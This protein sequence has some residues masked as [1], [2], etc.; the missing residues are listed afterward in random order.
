[1]KKSIIIVALLLHIFVLKSQIYVGHRDQLNQPVLD[2]NPE[3]FQPLVQKSFN[4]FQNVSISN[5]ELSD[6]PLVEG[7]LPSLIIKI[8][9]S[10][11][12][13]PSLKLGVSLQ[14]MLNYDKVNNRYG[15]IEQEPIAI[16]P[17]QCLWENCIGCMEIKDENGKIVNC[18]SC[19]P[20]DPMARFYCKIGREGTVEV[21]EALTG[22]LT[23]ITGLIGVL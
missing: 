6:N 18:S 15:G 2:I 8:S 12:E 3:V 22:L 1:M 10:E 7:Y 17:K 4:K 14:Y 13:N 16:G 20:T 23:A 19:F 5:I 11:P 21:I 9:F